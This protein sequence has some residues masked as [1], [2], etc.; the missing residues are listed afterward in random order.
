MGSHDRITVSGQG[1]ARSGWKFC[2][3][4]SRPPKADPVRAR[5]SQ[6]VE[7]MVWLW[8]RHAALQCLL[9]NQSM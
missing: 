5:Q 3:I 1:N 7:P 6:G 2:S 4:L 8:S 9:H